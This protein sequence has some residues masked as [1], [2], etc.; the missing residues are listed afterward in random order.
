MPPLPFTHWLVILSAIISVAGSCAYIRDT[1]SGKTKPNRVSW[2]MWAFAPLVGTCAAFSVHADFWATIRVFLA[3]FLPLLVFF[4]TFLNPKSYWKLT[5]FDY[6]C[7]SFSLLAIIVWACVDSARMAILLLALGDGLASIPTIRK[8]WRYPA[9]ETGITYI[10]SFLSV[11]LVLPSIP[12]WN[13]EN[14]AFQIQLL[15]TNI[16]LLF[17]VYQHFFGFKIDD[18]KS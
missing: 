9:T 15:I 13:I 18:S 6:L 12:V 3:G 17:C 7:G 16:L 1:I 5:V 2:S 10:A 14:A 4:A 11:V 8:A